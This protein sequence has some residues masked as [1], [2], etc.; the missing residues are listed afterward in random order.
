MI[1]SSQISQTSKLS[2]DSTNDSVVS[3]LSLQSRLTTTV[4]VNLYSIIPTITTPLLELWA[5][6]SLYKSVENQLFPHLTNLASIVFLSPISNALVERLLSLMG[7]VKNKL[8][9]K[10]T[11]L[12]VELVLGVRFDLCC[13]GETSDNFQILPGMLARFNQNMYNHI[14]ALATPK[15]AANE[16]STSA[17]ESVDNDKDNELR[18]ILNNVEEFGEPVFLAE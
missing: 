4:T 11:I 14:R 10:L 8:R 17:V 1:S 7:V 13:R 12:M 18:E 15:L 16:A 2:V 5:V 9:N 3:L 6:V